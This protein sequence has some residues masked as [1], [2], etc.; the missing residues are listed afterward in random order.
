MTKRGNYE[1]P[2][3]L[4]PRDEKFLA[5]YFENK[6]NATEAYLA[7]RPEASRKHAQH[8]GCMYMK[9]PW[10]R[11]AIKERLG[12]HNITIERVLSE[13]A[14]MA[15]LDPADLLDD[16]GMVR[17]LS[18]MPEKARRAIAGMDI[19]LETDNRG[20]VVKLRIPQKTKALELLGKY[21]GLFVE[22]S[23]VEHSGA[24]QLQVATGI[25]KGP[26]EELRGA[27]DADYERCD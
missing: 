12:Q 3:R 24:V 8:A 1:D 2:N 10:I 11:K 14:T 13:L 22:K 25:P 7:L 23:Q 6:H 17:P 15:Y 27:Q 5:A 26:K 21:L 9:K 20:R 16:N 4:T 18:E 19:E